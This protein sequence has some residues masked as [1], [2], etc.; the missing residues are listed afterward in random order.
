[1]ANCSC[2]SSY[3]TYVA[4]CALALLFL[5]FYNYVAIIGG[6]QNGP[7]VILV[8]SESFLGKDDITANH[9]AAFA[10]AKA[11][12]QT[13][14]VSYNH[15]VPQVMWTHYLG[16]D[17]TSTVELDAITRICSE[18]NIAHI[19]LTESNFMDFQ[20]GYWPEEFEQA[21]LDST[22]GI[23]PHETSAE[24]LSEYLR[25]YIGY[26]F[27]GGYTDLLIPNQQLDYKLLLNNVAID[28]NIH[29]AGPYPT[30]EDVVCSTYGCIDVYGKTDPYCCTRVK[31][32]LTSY[33]SFSV[34]A[35]RP[36]C[37]IC[38]DIIETASERSKHSFSSRIRFLNHLPYVAQERQ[39]NHVKALDYNVHDCIESIKVEEPVEVKEEKVEPA[40]E[41]IKP[42]EEAIEPAEEAIEPAEEAIKPAEEA[43]KPVEVKKEKKEKIKPVEKAI[44]QSRLRKTRM[45]KVD[46]IR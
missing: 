28:A 17:N 38:R 16:T 1:M 22:D 6:L 34:F 27:G 43:I 7:E 23:L 15:D 9:V 45:R 29:I 40:E 46:L 4:V 20:V 5:I 35:S 13:M 36:G 26:F 24:R 18:S 33:S 30:I 39:I 37:L 2:A 3:R 41:A 42:V 32:K 21:V 12:L 14:G 10:S 19:H 44:E 25:A 11:I 8:R 31:S